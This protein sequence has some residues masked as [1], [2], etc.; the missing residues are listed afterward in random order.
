MNSSLNASSLTIELVT[1]PYLRYLLSTSQS[2]REK[3]G[4][5]IVVLNVLISSSSLVDDHVKNT[6]FVG[7]LWVVGSQR[8]ADLVNDGAENIDVAL[9]VASNV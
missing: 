8:A 5:F 9:G 1:V 4:R 7:Q 6:V 2:C 3:L